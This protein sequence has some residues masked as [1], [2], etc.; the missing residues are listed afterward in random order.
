MD[1]LPINVS[2]EFVGLDIL[3]IVRIYITACMIL[4]IASRGSSKSRLLPKCHLVSFGAQSIILCSNDAL[5]QVLASSAN[6]W[7]VRESKCVLVRL[8]VS[9]DG[10]STLSL[11]GLL[12]TKILS[13]VW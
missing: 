7:L 5:N 6:H 1:M 8:D 2:K 11:S 9:S 12:L 13:F 3:C 10:F 4:M